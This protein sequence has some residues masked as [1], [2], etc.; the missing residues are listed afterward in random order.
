[1]HPEKGV[2]L[3]VIRTIESWVIAGSHSWSWLII[4]LARSFETL[5]NQE[6]F[7][8]GGFCYAVKMNIKLCGL[9]QYV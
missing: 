9:H 1:M 5:I 7:S 8:N 6:F 2:S 4:F 3:A